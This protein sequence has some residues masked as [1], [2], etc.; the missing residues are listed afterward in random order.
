MNASGG[1]AKELIALVDAG[2]IRVIDV[3]IPQKDEDGSIEARPMRH[4]RR[5]ESDDATRTR[6]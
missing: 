4:S 3:L 1:P 2:T 6:T 5:K